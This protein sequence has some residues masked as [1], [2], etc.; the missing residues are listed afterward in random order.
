MIASK[1]GA[2]GTLEMFLRN[3]MNLHNYSGPLSEIFVTF[4]PLLL[5][6]YGCSF[7]CHRYWSLVWCFFFSIEFFSFWWKNMMTEYISIILWTLFKMKWDEQ[8]FCLRFFLV[9]FTDD[10]YSFFV[11]KF[12]TQVSRLFGPC[13]MVFFYK[14]RL[15]N[16]CS[17]KHSEWKLHAL[18]WLVF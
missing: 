8:W 5:R 2:F 6:P 13:W 4:R 3:C 7:F 18:F 12:G 17:S 9:M 14:K 10:R 11:H 16:K 1:I 15:K